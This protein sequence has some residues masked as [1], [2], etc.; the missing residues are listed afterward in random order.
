MILEDVLKFHTPP[1]IASQDFR[2]R[3]PSVAACVVDLGVAFAVF[4]VDSV[5]D[6]VVGLLVLMLLEVAISPTKTCTPTILAPINSRAL[7]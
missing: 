3:V 7:D 1:R 5:V 2:A 4:V 6:S